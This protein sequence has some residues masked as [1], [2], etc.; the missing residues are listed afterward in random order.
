M[1]SKEP[2]DDIPVNVLLVDDQEANL[3]ALEAM[4]QGL[5]ANLVK[6]RSGDE[7]IQHLLVEDFAVVLLDVMMPGKDGFETARL[8]RSRPQT[9]HTPV[10]FLTARDSG[11]SDVLKAYRGG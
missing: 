7:A 4:L 1:A 6:A 8:I 9:R 5:G 11:D 2:F 10:I 3:T